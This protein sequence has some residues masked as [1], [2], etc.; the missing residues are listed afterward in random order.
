MAD[1]WT[2]VHLHRLLKTST[3]PPVA[4]TTAAVG[5]GREPVLGR[6][7]VA[8]DVIACNHLS[9]WFGKGLG[10]QYHD[11]QLVGGIEGAAPT[12]RRT[13]RL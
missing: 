5:V 11:S 9:A 13:A 8:D 1:R 7:Q 2:T 12:T 10:G 6:H 4:C 3:M